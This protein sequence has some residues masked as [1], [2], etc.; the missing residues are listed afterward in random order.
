MADLCNHARLDVFRSELVS[1]AR[2]SAVHEFPLLD[3]TYFVPE[4]SIPFEKALRVADHR[5]RIHF[6]TH[7]RNFECV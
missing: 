1:D 2:F 7:D 4:K 3:R 6:Y 5:Q